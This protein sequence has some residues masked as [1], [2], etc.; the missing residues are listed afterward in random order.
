MFGFGLTS[1]NS[2]LANLIKTKTDYNL[3]SDANGVIVS[4]V[5]KDYALVSYYYS[6][7]ILL[8]F[9]PFATSQYW[10]FVVC[11]ATSAGIV[12]SVNVTRDLYIKYIEQ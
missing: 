8:P 12:P 2:K 5:S 10:H 11:D 3:T 1:L 7:Y 4:S 9:R 6:N